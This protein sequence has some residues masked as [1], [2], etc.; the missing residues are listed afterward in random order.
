MCKKSEHNQ[1]DI[2]RLF[3]QCRRGLLELDILLHNYLHINIHK[4]SQQEIQTFQNLL[5]YPDNLL[6]EYLMGR[7]IPMDKEI[8]NVVKRVRNTPCR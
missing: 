2:A 4:L 7:T 1:T 5:N 8:A 6:L 3:W